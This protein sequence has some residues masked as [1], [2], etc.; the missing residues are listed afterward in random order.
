MKAITYDKLKIRREVE[1]EQATDLI[2]EI[3]S[4]TKTSWSITFTLSMY[5]NKKRPVYTEQSRKIVETTLLDNK[6]GN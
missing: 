4:D 5:D 1:I 3:V 2:T 6:G